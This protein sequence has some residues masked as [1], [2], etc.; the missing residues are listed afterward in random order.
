MAKIHHTAIVAD[1]A[2]LGADVEVGPYASIGENV[3][4]GSGTVVK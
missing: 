3:R 4:I 1:G 2:V